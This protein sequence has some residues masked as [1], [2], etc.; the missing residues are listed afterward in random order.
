M[1]LGLAS[2]KG[3]NS[4]DVG[5]F[6]TYHNF[7]KLRDN[8]DIMD[9]R[10]MV[11]STL[12]NQKKIKDK[13]SQAS[14][15][16]KL[17]I[18]RS[19]YDDTAQVMSVP[20]FL[21]EQA[22]AHMEQVKDIG[23]KQ[24][25]VEKDKKCDEILDILSAVFMIVP[26]VGEIGAAAAGFSMIARAFSIFGIVSNEA[27]LVADVAIHPESAPLAVMG[28]ILGTVGA[29][30]VFRGLPEDTAKIRR[31]IRSGTLGPVFKK[32][33]DKLQSILAKKCRAK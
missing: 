6:T 31:S 33:D 7:P 1:K 2:P 29:K 13:L 10:K 28:M 30:G 23:K 14:A 22:I 24:Q 11:Q 15:Y 32:N 9:P 12:S 16:M 20:V 26:F 25:Q 18:W 17:G 5:H 8:W 3:R 21:Y 19:D 4:T 27:V